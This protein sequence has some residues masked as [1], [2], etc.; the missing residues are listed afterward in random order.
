MTRTVDPHVELLERLVR[1][2]PGVI[3]IASPVAW[4]VDDTTRRGR[5][6]LERSR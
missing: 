1:R 3:S 6:A 5:R 2:V 4:Q